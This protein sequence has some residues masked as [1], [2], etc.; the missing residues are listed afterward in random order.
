MHSFGPNTFPAHNSALFS[1]E[2]QVEYVTKSLFRPIMDHRASLIEVKQ[3]AEDYFANDMQNQLTG[4]VFSAGCSNWYINS[5]G[6]NS[7]SWPGYASSFWRQTFFPKF[8]DFELL[9]GDKFWFTKSL[10]RKLAK[11]LLSKYTIAGLLVTFGVLSRGSKLFVVKSG[12]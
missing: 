8:A 1:C 11:T 5:A 12:V 3:S 2:V 9:D 6:R 4:S 7:A 10:T